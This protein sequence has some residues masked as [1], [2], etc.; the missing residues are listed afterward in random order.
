MWSVEALEKARSYELVKLLSERLSKHYPWL[1]GCS[2]QQ[3]LARL[4]PV[5][6]SPDNRLIRFFGRDCPFP[7]DDTA[8][9]AGFLLDQFFSGTPLVHGSTIIVRC[10]LPVRRKV[11]DI[12]KATAAYQT[13]LIASNGAGLYSW[14][15][16][17]EEFDKPPLVIIPKP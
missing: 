11:S 5:R 15:V 10:D 14:Q 9:V 17:A 12:L 4:A 3:V 2:V 1:I 8:R 13:G 16:P 6:R 7:H